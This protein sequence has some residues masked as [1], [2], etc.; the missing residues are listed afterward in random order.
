MS[1]LAGATHMIDQVDTTVAMLVGFRTVALLIGATF[2]FLGY[3]LFKI[4]YFERA[5]ELQAAWVLGGLY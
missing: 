3:S 4:G 5:G 1:V 2:L